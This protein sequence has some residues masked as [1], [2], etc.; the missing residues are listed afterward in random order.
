MIMSVNLA[1]RVRDTTLESLQIIE[2]CCHIRKTFVSCGGDVLY[3]CYYALG[4]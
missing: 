4:S 3:S 2:M 1:L